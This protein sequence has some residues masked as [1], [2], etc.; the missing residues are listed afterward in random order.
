MTQ[1][2]GTLFA[3]QERIVAKLLAADATSKEK[4]V[5]AADGGLN[6]QEQNCLSYI[7]GGFLARAKK[8]RDKRY[9]VVVHH[10]K[11]DSPLPQSKAPHVS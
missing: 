4:A 10:Q 9:Y 11:Y 7:A 3:M 6:I 8:T 5:S 1:V 2:S